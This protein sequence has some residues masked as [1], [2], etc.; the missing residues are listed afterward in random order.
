M[1]SQRTQDSGRAAEIISQGRVV[2]FPTGTSYGL[3]VDALQGFALQRLRNLK[4]RPSE[5]TFTVFLTE[6]LWDEFLELAEAERALL[7]AM[8]GKALTLLVKP[9]EPLAHL[10]QEGRVGLRVI[11]HPLMLALA[12][13]VSVPLTATSANVSGGEPCFSPEA[14]AKTFP[15]ILDTASPHPIYGDLAPAG[16]TTYDLSLG[17]ILDGGALPHHEPTTIARLDGEQ[18]TIIRQGEL[19]VS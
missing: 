8:Q 5:K 16:D 9:K 6:S 19:I 18:V 3:A 12:D 17:C 13:A 10:A 14:I 15:S 7:R 2:A 11:D 1:I 4:L